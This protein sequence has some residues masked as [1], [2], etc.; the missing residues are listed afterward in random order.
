MFHPK[1]LSLWF[2]STW[3]TS[4]TTHNCESWRSDTEYGM[5][6]QTWSKIFNQNAEQSTVK[7]DSLHSRCK[8]LAPIASRPN[9]EKKCIKNRSCNLY[10]EKCALCHRLASRR[11]ANN[12]LCGITFWK[13]YSRIW[14]TTDDDVLATYTGVTYHLWLWFTGRDPMLICS[15]ILH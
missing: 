6:L 9:V 1:K 5:C 13:T 12:H 4:A 8:W 2:W 15:E 14:V 7:C 3:R 11:R 10:R